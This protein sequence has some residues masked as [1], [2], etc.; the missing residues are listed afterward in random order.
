MDNGASSYHRFLE[1]DESGF[2]ELLDLYQDNLIFF[3][4]RFVHNLTVAEDLAEDSFLELLIHKQRFNFKT[5]LKT[6]LFTIGRN[7]ALNYLKHESK[8]RSVS[9]EDA[10]R[11]LSDL[12]S[13]EESVLSE[14]R[15]RLVNSAINEL[16][17][18]YRA[19]IHLVYFE[20]LSYEEAARVLKKNKKQTENLVCRARNALRITLGKEGVEL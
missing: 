20:D 11:E 1:G 10:S 17:D 5:S 18:D 6:Y 8:F 2:D 9:L 3:I 13:L 14:E 15:K 19:V 4:N 12:T 16:K 7:K